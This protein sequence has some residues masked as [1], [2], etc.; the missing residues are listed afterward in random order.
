MAIRVS[1]STDPVEE[2]RAGYAI[3]KALGLRQQGPELIACP[4]C[5]RTNVEVHSLA[6]LVEGRLAQYKEH[7][8]VAVMGWASNGPGGAGDADVRLRGVQD[9]QADAGAADERGRHERTGGRG[10]GQTQRAESWR[11][12]HGVDG[13]RGAGGRA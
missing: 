10:P 1:L 7:F 4:S 12:A 3:L 2:V 9:D 6:E 5:G 11:H 13:R 8:E